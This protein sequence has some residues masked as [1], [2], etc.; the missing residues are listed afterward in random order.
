MQQLYSSSTISYAK[1]TRHGYPMRVHLA[2]LQNRIR[3]LKSKLKFISNSRS[4][5]LKILQFLGFKPNDFEMGTNMIFFRLHRFELFQKF[6][7]DFENDSD[8]TLKQMK[9]Y[10]I[11]SNWRYIGFVALMLSKFTFS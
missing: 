2:E 1:F 9:K 6:I 10:L 7:K 11:K 8:L 5:D 4:L 3:P